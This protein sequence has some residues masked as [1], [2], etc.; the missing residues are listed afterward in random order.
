MS[1]FFMLATQAP[2]KPSAL[3]A[4]HIKQALEAS[5]TAMDAIGTVTTVASWAL[6]IMGLFI[7]IVAFFGFNIIR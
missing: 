3:E 6:T 4:D 5:Q 7:A 1:I 2:H